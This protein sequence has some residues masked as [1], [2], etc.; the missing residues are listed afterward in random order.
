MGLEGD[1]SY[2]PIYK[3]SLM[4]PVFTDTQSKEQLR[5]ILAAAAAQGW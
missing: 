1:N 4:P 3:P 2:T 5:C